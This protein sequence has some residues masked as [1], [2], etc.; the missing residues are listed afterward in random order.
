MKEHQVTLDHILVS[1]WHPDHIGGVKT[2]Q[3]SI[4]KG[5]LYKL[6]FPILNCYHKNNFKSDCKISKFHIEDRPTE[7]EKLT[8][9]QEVSV[10]GANLK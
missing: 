7:F 8:D 2:I 5:W 4:N 10:E 6:Y 1:H 3:Q 9:G